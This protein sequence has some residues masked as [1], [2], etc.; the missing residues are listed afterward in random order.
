MFYIAEPKW[1]SFIPGGY[2]PGRSLQ[3][4]GRPMMYAIF[5]LAGC[6]ILFF[7]YDAGIM[8]LVLINPDFLEHM[9]TAT[10]TDR[11]AAANGGLVSLWFLGFL[12]GMLLRLLMALLQSLTRVIRSH[13]C[14]CL[15]RQDR[16]SQNHP[17]WLCMGRYWSGP[18]SFSNELHL[19]VFRSYHRRCRLR[20]SQCRRADLDL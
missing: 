3:L 20:S 14:W 19:D 11:D 7:G 9:G 6:A 15:R 10:G 1:A 16:A 12:F 8:A 17:G 5:A 13:P 4:R 18:A 2:S